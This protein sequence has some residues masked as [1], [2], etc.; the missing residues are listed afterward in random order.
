MPHFY[1]N[2]EIVIQTNP[3]R[4]SAYRIEVL[5]PFSDQFS[6]DSLVPFGL[7]TT[8]QP[9]L[10]S[11]SIGTQVQNAF[12]PDSTQKF[13]MPEADTSIFFGQPRHTLLPRRLYAFYFFGRNLSGIYSRKLVYAGPRGK[14]KIMVL[15]DD[16]SFNNDD[17]VAAG[18]CSLF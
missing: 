17:P 2:E 4:D 15:R 18:W 13:Y 6:S 9:A 11:H 16:R 5:N 14:T 3:V 10:V 1:R 7:N 12:F 8:L